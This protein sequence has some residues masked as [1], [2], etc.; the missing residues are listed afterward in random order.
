MKRSKS[1]QWAA[2][3]VIAAA[4][5]AGGC[6]DTYDTYQYQGCTNS[7][8][9]AVDPSFCHTPHPGFVWYYAPHP[10]IIGAHPYGGG[11]SRTYVSNNHWYGSSSGSKVS[12]TSGSFKGSSASPVSRGGFGST[13]SGFGGGS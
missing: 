3:G 8:G 13:G 2:L 12:S 1:I 4:V 6:D 11:I 5:L 7:A 10:I 9:V